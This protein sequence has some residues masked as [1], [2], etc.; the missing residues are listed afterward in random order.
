M[1]RKAESHPKLRALVWKEEYIISGCFYPEA[2][3]VCAVGGPMGSSVVVGQPLCFRGLDLHLS[4]LGLGLIHLPPVGP[5]EEA[6]L[7][8]EGARL[9]ERLGTEGTDESHH[10]TAANPQQQIAGL[11]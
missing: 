5:L 10:S 7:G 3:L 1:L 2:P 4:L 6:T 9:D 11:A 8:E